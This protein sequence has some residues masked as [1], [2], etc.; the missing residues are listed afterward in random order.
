MGMPLYALSGSSKTEGAPITELDQQS[1]SNIEDSKR[2]NSV[3]P[4]NRTGSGNLAKSKN[5][6]NSKYL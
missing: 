6:L 4:L 2:A 5:Y 1:N 3:G